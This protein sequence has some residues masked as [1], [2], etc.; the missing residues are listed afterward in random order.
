[1][2]EYKQAGEENMIEIRLVQD[3]PHDAT[4]AIFGWEPNTAQIIGLTGEQLNKLASSIIETLKDTK[5][6]ITL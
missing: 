5:F 4:F 6:E 1:M 3:G 2:E